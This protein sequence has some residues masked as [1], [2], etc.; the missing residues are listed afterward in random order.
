MHYRNVQDVSGNFWVCWQES[1]PTLRGAGLTEEEARKSLRLHETGKN[2]WGTIEI[3]YLGNLVVVRGVN[4]DDAGFGPTLTEAVA[5]LVGC[6]DPKIFFTFSPN[7]Q[8]EARIDSC[9][10]SSKHP[11]DAFAAL[12]IARIEHTDDQIL[13][14]I[15]LA[16]G[17][18]RKLEEA[19]RLYNLYL[20]RVTA[21]TELLRDFLKLLPAEYAGG[22]P[23]LDA[24]RERLKQTI[25]RRTSE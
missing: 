12:K 17:T 15:G 14:R 4:K 22:S 19:A 13:R 10:F 16:V 8:W 21:D 6:K 11:W 7:D 3:T 2:V 25:K 18:G 5:D 1:E 24:V 20:E 23:T 9:C